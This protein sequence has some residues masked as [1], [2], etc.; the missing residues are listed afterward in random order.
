[1][2]N[3]MCLTSSLKMPTAPSLDEHAAFAPGTR[4]RAQ[5]GLVDLALEEDAVEGTPHQA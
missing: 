2:K 3:G 4:R 5:A 1:M